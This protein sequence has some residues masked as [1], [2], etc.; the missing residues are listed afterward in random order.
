MTAFNS[1]KLPQRVY[2]PNNHSAGYTQNA[3]EYLCWH[4]F[5]RPAD[6]CFQASRSTGFLFRQYG[7]LAV[8]GDVLGDLLIGKLRRLAR[9]NRFRLL[10]RGAALNVQAAIA[11]KQTEPL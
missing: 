10:L 7:L 11:R 9:V 2:R 4:H 3:Q 5:P 6:P 1:I 8:S